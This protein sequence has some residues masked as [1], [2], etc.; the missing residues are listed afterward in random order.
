LFDVNTLYYFITTQPAHQACAGWYI[1][2]I[3]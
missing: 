3:L 2:A 1:R